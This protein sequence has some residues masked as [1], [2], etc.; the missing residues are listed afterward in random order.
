M[1]RSYLTLFALLACILVGCAIY[2]LANSPGRQTLD[3]GQISQIVQ[4]GTPPSL[5]Q[6]Q[7]W[8]IPAEPQKGQREKHTHLALRIYWDGASWPV[9]QRLGYASN[10]QPLAI[11]THAADAVVHLHLPD[12][13]K[14]FTLRQVL[15]LWG[16]PLQ[17]NQIRGE[18]LWIWKNGKPWNN[19]LNQPIPDKAD[20]VIEIDSRSKKVPLR[21]FDWSLIP[22]RSSN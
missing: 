20:V 13:T 10:G 17:G 18:D 21:K 1:K 22:L 19:G 11:H 2:S 16:L 12:G 6:A 15:E 4:L 8:G 9:P 7:A 3:A 14:P 5:G